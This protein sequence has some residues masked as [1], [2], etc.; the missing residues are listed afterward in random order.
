MQFSERSVL[1]G[2]LVFAVGVV[3]GIGIGSASAVAA[4]TQGAPD[5]LRQI[6]SRD[7][8]PL[9][10]FLKRLQRFLFG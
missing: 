2:L 7:K 8:K 9:R 4:L 6:F 10:Q 1:T 5:V 3:V